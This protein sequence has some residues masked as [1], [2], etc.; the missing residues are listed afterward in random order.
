MGS[1]VEF[2]TT[3]LPF[4]ASEML[5]PGGVPPGAGKI[6]PGQEI[7]FTTAMVSAATEYIKEPDYQ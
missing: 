6:S 7:Y 1:P 2:A 5:A 3:V 4:M